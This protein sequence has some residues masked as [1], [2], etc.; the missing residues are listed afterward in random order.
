MYY[1][2]IK[3]FFHLGSKG[4]CGIWT[5]VGGDLALL[6]NIKIFLLGSKEQQGTQRN[7]ILLSQIQIRDP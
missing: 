4:Q 7:P 6:Q 3:N 1:K 5:M 2:E